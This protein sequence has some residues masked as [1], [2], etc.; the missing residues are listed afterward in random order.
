[1]VLAITRAH[2]EAYMD[3]ALALAEFGRG[4]TSPNPMVGA[5]LV[6]S[7]GIVVGRGYHVTAAESHAEIKALSEAG[8][9]SHGATLYCTL[10]PCCHQGRTG[11]CV[12]RIL[13]AGVTRVVVGTIDPDPR[14][15]GKGV[16]YLRAKGVLV[17]VGVREQAAAR[18]NE[19]FSTWVLRRRPF[20]TMKV[21]MSCDGGIA[22]T[23][24][25]R[26]YLTSVAANRL[27]HKLR[28][29]VDAIGVGSATVLAD[30]PKL[31][32]RGVPRV[33]PLTRVIFDRRLRVPP[34]SKV[35]RTL[36]EGP[37]IVFTSEQGMKSRSIEADRL[38]AAGAHL[39]VLSSGGLGEALQR[40]AERE[41]TAL[42]LEG[43]GT[44]HRAAWSARLVD[45]VCMFITP[46]R[47]GTEGV[48]WLGS[49]FSLTSLRDMAI[50]SY[51]PDTLIEG[52]VQR[53]D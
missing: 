51:G 24:G 34:T 5:V 40:L 30:D 8:L 14:V 22:A 2:D 49:Q 50:S 37:V 19:V 6:S 13:A 20:V 9:A 48:Q 52:Y 42:L 26:T 7:G 3:E 12:N 15:H 39:E 23:G 36:N 27:V 38:R 29:Q 11:P 46:T 45:K 21:A 31:T 41:V 53:V 25:Q 44:I 4:R 17:E 1:M 18:L 35:F 47:L 33:R 43:G 10:E 28:S 32:V 16:A